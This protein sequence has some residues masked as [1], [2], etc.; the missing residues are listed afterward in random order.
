MKFTA[1]APISMGNVSVGF[2][3]LGA[4]FASIDE[5]ET[6][7]GDRVT[8]EAADSAAGPSAGAPDTLTVDG[9]F[10]HILP[11]DHAQN[12]ALIAAGYYRAA[13]EAKGEGCAPMALHLEKNLPIGSGLGSSASTVVA[14][15]AAMNEFAE[16]PFTPDELVVI[17]GRAEG[18]VS[19]GV[20]LDNVAGS[21]LGGLRLLPADG[22]DGGIALPGADHWYWALAYPGTTMLTKEGRAVL[23][24]SVPFHTTIEAAGH[25]A[26]FVSACYRGDDEAA[27]EH[28]VDLLA[29]PHRA[30]LLPGFA[31][32]K[33]A[34]PGLGAKAVGISGSGPTMFA[35]S[36]T[37]EGADKLAD[38]L[39]AHYLK[40]ENG[41]CHVCKLQNEGAIISRLE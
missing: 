32:A 29:E 13:L 27:W 18:H 6:P 8:A 17:M 34:L 3:I 12:L 19:G 26:S 37:R 40:N 23:P 10:A 20:H 41:F 2:D 38:Y 9:P 5:T 15:L 39:R 36:D 21:Y 11:G 33:A 14:A 22:S 4:A 1:F 30:K 35:I 7:L 28:L 24:E 16:R 31:E 25:L